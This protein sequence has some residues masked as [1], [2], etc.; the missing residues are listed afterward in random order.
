VLGGTRFAG[1]T[2]PRRCVHE[3][4]A[5][6]SLSH[7]HLNHQ[8]DRFRKATTTAVHPKTTKNTRGRE[9]ACRGSIPPGWPVIEVQLLGGLGNRDNRFQSANDGY[10][11]GGLS[12]AAHQK[13]PNHPN[14]VT[15]SE[16]P[17]ETSPLP[18][19]TH[20]SISNSHT[21]NGREW[22]PSSLGG[23]LPPLTLISM[24]QL[25]RRFGLPHWLS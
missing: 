23:V 17:H 21:Q 25:F 18:L 9:C 12:T 20:H 8:S 5:M 10:S 13:S 7:G 16:H 6:L 2:Q 19:S 4:S 24:F 1:K 22:R 11:V 3:V 15:A 14:S